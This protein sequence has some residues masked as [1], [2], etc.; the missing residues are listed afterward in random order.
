MLSLVN[1]KNTIKIVKRNLKLNHLFSHELWILPSTTNEKFPKLMREKS[2]WKVPADS[3]LIE[4]EQKNMTKKHKRENVSFFF[5]CLHH[6]R[7]ID[8]TS[9]KRKKITEQFFVFW[10]MTPG[11]QSPKLIVS[12][13][14]SGFL[15]YQHLIMHTRRIH[16]IGLRRVHTPVSLLSGESCNP[17]R[18]MTD[19]K[20]RS[21][22]M[23]LKERVWGSDFLDSLTRT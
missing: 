8:T 21:S 12:T 11:Q 15:S 13:D 18:S 5:F 14:L 7:G 10:D 9:L 2:T 22:S 4:W 1:L 20:S 16:G 23:Y 19:S 17:F 3:S 6:K